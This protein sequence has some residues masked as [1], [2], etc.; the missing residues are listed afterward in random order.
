M[1]VGGAD[2]FAQMLAFSQT[3]VTVDQANA[4]AT[5]QGRFRFVSHLGRGSFG[6]V[7]KAYDQTGRRNVAVK[8]FESTGAISL[9]DLLFSG[10]AERRKLEEAKKEA[11]TLHQLRHA[12]IVG[13]I[14]SYE[15]SLEGS[16][17]GF[18]I[19]TRFCEKGSLHQYLESDRPSEAKRL[20]WYKQLAAALQFIHYKNITHRD[21]KPANILIDSDD[22]LKICDVGLAKA[23]WD[24]QE[25]YLRQSGGTS[26]EDYMTTTAGTVPYMAP[27]VWNRH[28]DSRSDIFSL[29]LVYMMIAES[30]KPLLPRAKWASGDETALG[31]L[32]HEQMPPRTVLASSILVPA[33]QYAR[34]SEI[35][36]FDKM[37][38][39]D[40]H[41][42]PDADELAV[43]LITIEEM[44]GIRISSSSGSNP[45]PSP[46]RPSGC[47]CN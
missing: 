11:E 29:G 43:E 17:K 42:R 24:I 2:P 26:L 3:P 19:V 8:L 10:A 6:T 12:C 18:A 23:V 44:S 13:Y 40:F 46:E 41:H 20:G 27:E 15:Y 38:K 32:L 16:R 9:F 30:P 35:R 1:A 45:D 39:F 25:V 7:L 37:L 33:P 22:S 21:L 4:R 31:K 5:N 47:C 36:L 34:A 28:Y 14:T